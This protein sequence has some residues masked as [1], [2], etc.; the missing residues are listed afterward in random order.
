VDKD[1]FFDDS[2]PDELGL[3]PISDDIWAVDAKPPVEEISTAENSRHEWVRLNDVACSEI[4]QAKK[5]VIYQL[6]LT[7]WRK[8]SGGTHNPMFRYQCRRCGLE[9]A[10]FRG[11]THRRTM[12]RRQFMKVVRIT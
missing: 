6:N 8:T 4:E 11:K 2:D 7:G 9:T 5:I 3:E 10:C 12:G 1:P